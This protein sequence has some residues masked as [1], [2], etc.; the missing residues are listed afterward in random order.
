MLKSGSEEAVEYGELDTFLR[1][2]E[3]WIEDEERPTLPSQPI[4]VPGAALPLQMT[5]EHLKS[6]ILAQP[7][8]SP[9]KGKVSKPQE[10]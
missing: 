6:K 5:P 1:L 7:Q 4:G 2:K 10:S 3:A 9:L 8:S